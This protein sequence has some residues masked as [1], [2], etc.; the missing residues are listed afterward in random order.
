MQC[1]AVQVLVSWNLEEDVLFTP[2]VLTR[3]MR[4]IKEQPDKF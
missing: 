1:S 2:L 3:L 4:E